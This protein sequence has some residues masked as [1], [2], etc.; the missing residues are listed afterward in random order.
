VQRQEM[1]GANRDAV[2]NRITTTNATAIVSIGVEAN[3]ANTNVTTVNSGETLTI[4][5][6][7]TE[8]ATT[9]ENA[10]TLRNQGTF[11]TSD[12]GTVAADGDRLANPGRRA[13]RNTW[14]GDSPPDITTLVV[15]DDNTGLSRSNTALANQTNSASVSQTL[16]DAKTVAFSASVTQTGVRELGLEAADGTLITRATFDSGVDL[17]GTVTVTLD[18]S[19]DDGVSR[20]VLT[21]DGQTA[22]RDVLADNSPDLPTNYAY[23]SDNTAVAESDT[24]LANELVSVP[25]NKVPVQNADTQSEWDGI[26]SSETF[27]PTYTENGKLK[28]AQTAFVQEGETD[29]F[30]ANTRGDSEY[31]G[32][33]ATYI[34]LGDVNNGDSTQLTFDLDYTLEEENIAFKVRTDPT[35]GTGNGISDTPRFELNIDGTSAGTKQLNTNNLTLEWRDFGISW[36][37]GNLTPGSHTFSVEV[38]DDS[39]GTAGD[40][41]RFDAICIYDGRFPPTFDN[42]NGGSGGYLDGPELYPSQVTKAI[43]TAT[44]RRKVDKSRFELTA[45]DVSNNFFVELSGDGGSTYSRVQNSQTGDVTFSDPTETVDANVGLGR[46]S[47]T[48]TTATPQTGFNGQ[49]IDVWELFVF[50]PAVSPDDI[51]EVLSRGIVDPGTITGQ[52]V[53]EA[54]LKNGSTL[55]TRHLLAEFTPVA[56]ERIA[57]AESTLFTSDN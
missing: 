38:V 26:I 52:T 48:R 49:D 5:S 13:V 18:V 6:G 7:E 42:N 47:D 40:E 57:S 27:K 28:L 19:N 22:V 3:I 29:P 8:T 41:L 37:N 9:V 16:P 36:T 50:P 14:A 2:S 54:G 39:A 34:A 25:L 35:D 32:G 24:A 56:N 1:A 30:G 21:N 12:S 53:R 55:L 11:E 46:T 15:G 23:G 44:A 51:D 20:G 17:G 10:G 33:E 4:N 45:N 31:S 43:D